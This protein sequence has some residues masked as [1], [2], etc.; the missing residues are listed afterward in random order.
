M[1][2]NILTANGKLIFERIKGHCEKLGIYKE[3]DE[4]EL[5]PLAHNYDLY[6][7]MAVLCRDEGVT[8]KPK[9]GGW[10]QVRPEYTVMQKSYAY[11]MKHSAK[12]GMNPGDRAK[13]F[14][15]KKVESEKD[16][17]EELNHP[18]NLIRNI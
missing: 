7:Q 4:L 3:I 13:I 1:N 11:I 12:F 18:F 14:D 8:Q 17:L 5:I 16:P 2:K 10:D 15:I 9:N 6:M